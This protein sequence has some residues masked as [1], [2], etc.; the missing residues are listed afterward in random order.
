MT[1]AVLVIHII[2]AAAW[3]GA[4]VLLVAVVQPSL[5]AAGPEAAGAVEPQIFRRTPPIIAVSGAV[6]ILSGLWMYWNVSGGSAGAF[7]HTSGG[8]LVAAGAVCGIAAIVTGIVHGRTHGRGV[9]LAPVSVVLLL[10][11]LILMIVG[12]NV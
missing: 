11:A 6:T 7:I 2:A 5:H 8:M 12:S 10:A 3:F 9:N 4:N 1:V